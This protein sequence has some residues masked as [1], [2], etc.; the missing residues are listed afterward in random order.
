MTTI[1]QVFEKANAQLIEAIHRELREQG[2][3]LTGELER[4]VQGT[5][6][7][8]EGD[9]TLVGTALDYG[10]ILNKGVTAARIPFGGS[11]GDGKGTSKYIQALIDYFK[12]RG[13]DDKEAMRAAFATAHKHKKEGMP[14]STSKKHSTTGNRLNFI[15]IVND[16]ISGPLD[17]VIL[18][19]IN[20]IVDE[21]F[22]ETKS[23]RI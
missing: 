4:S 23:E 7:E 2:H 10:Q 16:V 15:G 11:N 8:T 20:T 3:Y 14:T 22:H 18:G 12:K 1:R 5:V 9:A 17:D 6:T 13:L 19:G 21:V